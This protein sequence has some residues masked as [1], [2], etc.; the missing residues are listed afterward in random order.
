MN[1]GILLVDKPQTWTSHDVVAKLRGVLRTKRIGHAG[2]LDPLATGVLV[3]MV[4]RATKQAQF[5]EANDKSYTAGIQ[6]G[7]TS[8]TYDITGELSEPQAVHVTRE[9]LEAALADFRGEISQIPP[10]FSAIKVAG[11]PLY[12]YARKGEEVELKPRTITIHRLELKEFD[13]TNA[14]LEIDCSKGTYIRSLA[15][16][17][18]AKLGCGGL[19]SSLIRTRSG[20]YSLADCHSLEEIIFDSVKN[21]SCT[22]LLNSI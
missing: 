5:L 10:I 1:E 22:F 14:I 12:K 20:I 7:I 3:V 13:G 8:N 11:K 18:G 17:I 2:T 6:L 21:G 16:D 9:Q 4:G 15:H 19:M